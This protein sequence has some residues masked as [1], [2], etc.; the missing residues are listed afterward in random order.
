VGFKSTSID[1]VP[2]LF[3]DHN[4]HPLVPS[5]PAVINTEDWGIHAS[6]SQPELTPFDMPGVKSPT[7]PELSGWLHKLRLLW[8]S[9]A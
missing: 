2:V 4:S 5:L 9:S 8:T 3:F 6:W 1:A 7:G